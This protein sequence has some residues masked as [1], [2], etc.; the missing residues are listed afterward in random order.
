MPEAGD[1]ERSTVAA[2]EEALLGGPRALTAADVAARAGVDPER[3]LRYRRLFGLPAADPSAPVFTEADAGAA[4]VVADLWRQHGLGPVALGQLVRSLG[5][6]MD[7][8]ARWQVEALVEDLAT[9]YELDDTSARLLALDRLAGL[10]PR[11]EALLAYA[12]RRQFAALAGQIGAELGQSR[13]IGA[14]SDALPYARAVG[15]ADVVAFTART[16]GLGS[17]GLSEF[18]QEFE[19]AAR[20][21]IAAE[22]GR[23]VKTIGDAVL[24][25]AD[26]AATGAAVAL[27]L[28]GRFG[29]PAAGAAARRTAPVRVSLVWGRVLSRFGDVFGPPV[30]LAARLVELAEPSAVWTDAGTAALLGPDERYALDRLDA[31]DVAGLGRVEPYRLRRA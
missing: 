25:I 20:D 28:A 3:V 22:G 31:R 2:L 21:V 11:L 1:D 29:D 10:E 24:F 16:A 18:V 4:G 5:H 6:T 23:V 14:R 9:R 17:S 19:A 27:G 8:L 15:F 7:R 13:G 30:T 12:F 26:D